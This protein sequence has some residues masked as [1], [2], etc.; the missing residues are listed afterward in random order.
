MEDL[1]SGA[2]WYFVFGQASPR[3]RVRLY[4]FARYDPAFNGEPQTRDYGALVLRRSCEVL[5]GDRAHLR[6]F[7]LHLLQLLDEWFKSSRRK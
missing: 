4:S 1:Y 6:A 7:A 5:A 2:S 3:E